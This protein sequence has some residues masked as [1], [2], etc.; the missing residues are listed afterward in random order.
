MARKITSVVLICVVLCCGLAA[1]T[2][3]YTHE[4]YDSGAPSST[5]IN[6]YRDIV[7]GIGFNDNYV[8]FRDSERSYIMVVGDLS[9]E[10]GVITLNEKGKAYKFTSTSTN[11]NSQYNYNVEEI[12]NFSVNTNNYIVYSDLADFPQLV[13]RGA[14]YEIISTSVIVIACICVVIGRIFRRR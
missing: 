10:G 3:A 8:A 12:S 9:C 14:N 5:Y 6:Y 1:T 2:H 13:E 11:Y 4:V 7:A